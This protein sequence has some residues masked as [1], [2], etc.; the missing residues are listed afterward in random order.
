MTTGPH[1]LQ[2]APLHRAEITFVENDYNGTQAA[3]QFLGTL[4]RQL[5]AQKSADFFGGP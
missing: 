1:C 4:G 3:V 5:S 2:T